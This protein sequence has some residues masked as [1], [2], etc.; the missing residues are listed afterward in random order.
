MSLFKHIPVRNK[1]LSAGYN[2]D[3]QKKLGLQNIPQLINYICLTYINQNEDEIIRTDKQ[4]ELID[5]TNK[6][7]LM[8]Y[9]VRETKIFRFKEQFKTGTKCEWL[10]NIARDAHHSFIGIESED[11]KEE[12]GIE[13]GPKS[14][15]DLILKYCHSCNNGCWYIIWCIS[16]DIDLKLKD[17]LKI[18]IQRSD[19]QTTLT[20]AT[21]E[22]E[23]TIALSAENSKL[24]YHLKIKACLGWMCGIDPNVSPYC[25]QLEKFQNTF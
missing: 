7:I 25:Y 4:R 8:N 13:T 9:T 10:L 15:P 16:I 5:N 23:H 6:R 3:Q 1:L 12:Y 11:Q 22:K 17:K 2:Y 14:G 19:E 18:T 21:D 24:A 20:F